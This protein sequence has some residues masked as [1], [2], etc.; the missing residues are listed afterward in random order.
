MRRLLILLGLP[1]A[2][3]LTVA[4]TVKDDYFEMSKQLEIMQSA[5]RE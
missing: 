5:F 1:L 4:S 3:F 2:L